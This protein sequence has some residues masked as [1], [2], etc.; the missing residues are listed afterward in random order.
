MF[1]RTFEIC[2][3]E[4]YEPNPACFL[5]ASVLAWQAR[6]K[7]T[8]AILDLLT[9]MDMLLYV[10]N[11]RKRYKKRNMSL[12]LSISKGIEILK[13]RNLYGWAMSQKLTVN[14]FKWVEYISEFD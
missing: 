13:Y 7:K 9:D 8:K 10:I 12:Y 5:T 1:L 2:C 6:L 4:M 3:L 14:D 11:A